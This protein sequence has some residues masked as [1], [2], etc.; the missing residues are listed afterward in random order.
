MIFNVSEFVEDENGGHFIH[1]TRE[2][3]FPESEE[4]HCDLCV[5]CGFPTYPE[6]RKYCPN[7]QLSQE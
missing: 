5:V 3:D 1:Y 2:K 7:E 4:R 6:C